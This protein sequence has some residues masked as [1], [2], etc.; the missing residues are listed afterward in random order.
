MIGRIVAGIAVTLP[1]LGGWH[2]VGPFGGAAAVVQ[3]DPHHP[4]TVL[5]ATNNGLLFRS[6]DSGGVL[7]FC[8]FPR[9]TPLRLACFLVDPQHRRYLFRRRFRRNARIFPGCSRR[10]TGV[11]TWS[12]LPGLAGKEVW[13]LAFSPSTSRTL[14]AGTYMVAYSFLT[15]AARVGND[16]RFHQSGNGGSR[17]AW[18]STRRTAGF[19]S[20]EL[21]T[22]HGKRAME[23]SLGFQSIA[24]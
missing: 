16:F 20:R 17:F 14:A 9:S 12:L 10:S 5:A 13:S 2:S 11:P 18:R 19:Y 8:P 21:L 24:A 23:A 6:T 1:L 22:Y 15:M 4:D 3:V 7:E